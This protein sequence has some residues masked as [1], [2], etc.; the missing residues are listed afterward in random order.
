MI[1][2]LKDVISRYV[3]RESFNPSLLGIFVNPFWIARRALWHGLAE[4][5]SVLSGR[6]LDVG[7]GS[8]PYQPLFSVSSYVGLEIDSLKSR[9]LGMADYFY[10]GSAFP[11]EDNSFDSVLCNQVLEHVFNPDAFIFEINR[12]LKPGGYLLLSVPFVWDEHEQPWDYARYSSFG[13]KFL[14]ENNNFKVLDQSKTVADISMVAQL[15]NAYIYKALPISQAIHLLANLFLMGPMTLLGLALAKILP[16][17][18]D[19]YLDQI[20]LAN[21]NEPSLPK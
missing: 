9:Q 17:N 16:N 11:F 15:I 18:S 7:C 10:D 1:S 5:S 12:V 6:L 20:V 13:L 14:L 3:A 2:F 21:K 19:L 4:K 8:K